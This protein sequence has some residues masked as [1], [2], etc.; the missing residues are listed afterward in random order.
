MSFF[1]LQL[2]YNSR[3]RLKQ[4][5]QKISEKDEDF[6]KMLKPHNREFEGRPRLEIDQPQLL[7]TILDIGLFYL[8]TCPNQ[9]KKQ[10]VF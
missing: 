9:F 3:L 2:F 4:T 5:I 7:S 10:F 8:Q 6:A 1:T